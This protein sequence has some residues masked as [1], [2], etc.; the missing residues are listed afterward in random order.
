M[1]DFGIFRG[2]G[3]K[4]F[5]DKLYAGQLPTQ[6]GGITASG[7]LDYYPNAAA[8]YSLRKLRSAYTGYAIRVRRSSDNTEQDI[9]FTEFNELNIPALTTFCGVYN[10]FITTWYDQSGNGNNATQST[11]ANQPQIVSSGSL[12]TTNGKPHIQFDGSNDQL[13]ANYVNTPTTYSHFVVGK[14]ITIAPN[15]YTILQINSNSLLRGNNGRLQFLTNTGSYQGV[16]I[17]VFNTN[18]NL[19]T[20]IWDGSQNNLALNN[21]SF[22]T[23]S[24]SGTSTTSSTIGIGWQ[25]SAGGNYTNLYA[26]EII[27]YTTNQISN[28]TGI[29]TNINSY[30]GIY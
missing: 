9:G 10:G 6:L 19:I 27:R 2:F 7:L 25:P 30:Y 16:D 17:G 18:Q 26:Q 11:A 8:A 3:S 13:N 21:N 14:V 24:V 12:L 4:L 28:R 22:V 23:G 29:S 15:V 20:A 1:P 5:S